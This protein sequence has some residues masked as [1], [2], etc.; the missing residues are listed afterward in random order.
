MKNI[1][2]FIYAASLVIAFASC[3]KVGDLPLYSAGIRPTL[4]ASATNIAPAATDS[5]KAALTLSWTD[6]MHATSAAN[7][8]YT[9]EIDSAGKNFSNP[10]TKIITG[11]LNTTFTAKDL[12]TF[13]INNGYAIGSTVSLDVRVTSSYANNNESLST[14]ALR[15][16]YTIYKIPPKVPVPT[17]GRLF[18]VGDATAG[19]WNNPVPVPSQEF[20]KLDETTWAGVFQLIGGKQYLA[21][22]VNGDWSNK[23]SINNSLPTNT[24]SSGAF[25]YNLNDNFNGPATSGLY[26][27]TLDFQNGKYTV[28]SYTTPLP[29]NLYLVGDA[30]PG[31]WN[32]P[33]PVPSQQFTRVNSS[34]WK[35][36][37]SLTGGKEYLIL[38]VN[39]DWSH[40]YSVANKSLA[41]LWKGGEFGYDL[42][43]NFPGPP[44]SATYT[45]TVNFAAPT[46]APNSA[47]KFTVQ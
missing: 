46:T 37:V 9:I 20:S 28:T 6:A 5:D 31:G 40:K 19:G 45:I 36:T 39:G 33:V 47:G 22:P 17:S 29:T 1:L 23:Y 26:K 14:D 12:N 25:G 10:F 21:L 2:K 8:K 35:I 34:E 27:I 38:P 32:N 44:T 3:K 24:G 16:K 18:L 13:L 41:N 15:I 11:A 4:A 43:D 30:S 7:V 42:P